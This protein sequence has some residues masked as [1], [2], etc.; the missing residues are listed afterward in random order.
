[1]FNVLEKKKNFYVDLITDYRAKKFINNINLKNI[2]FINIKTPTGK[3][4]FRINLF[5]NF[6]IYFIF[7]FNYFSFS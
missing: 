6:N 4:R 5:N 3:K 7:L 1:M 2:T